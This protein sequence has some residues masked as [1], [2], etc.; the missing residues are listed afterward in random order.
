ME[1]VAELTFYPSEEAAQGFVLTLGDEIIACARVQDEDV[2]I[3]IREKYATQEL[4]TLLRNLVTNWLDQPSSSSSA[5][6][7]DG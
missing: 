6:D 5:S 2:T 4:E 7:E 3:S 1:E